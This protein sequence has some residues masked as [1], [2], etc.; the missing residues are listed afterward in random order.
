[1][2]RPPCL[3]KPALLALLSALGSLLATSP[4]FCTPLQAQA[5]SA[6]NPASPSNPNPPLKPNAN[7]T[8]EE[9]EALVR[10]QIFLD[11]AWFAP[12]KIDGLPG[13]FTTKAV[14]AYQKAHQLDP[15]GLPE[16]LPLARQSPLYAQYTLREEDRKFVGDLPSKHA[17]QSKRKFLPY[18]SLAE[19][20]CEKF[21]CSPGLLAHL[22][23]EVILEKLQPGDQLKVPDVEPFLLEEIPV[24]TQLAEV[25]E[26][27]RRRV[28]VNRKERQLTL[29]DEDASVLAS[30]PITPGS[31]TLPTPA[32]NWRIVAISLLPN[33]RWD[34]GVL[35]FGVR[36]DQFFLLP[37]GPNNPVGVAWCALSKPGIGIHGTNQ[38]DTIGRAASHGCMRL[39]NWDAIRFSKLVTA[40]V[41]VTIE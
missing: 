17:D 28:H 29:H 16:D 6:A 15:T 40:G 13:E 34:E 30:F 25:P 37:P 21:H 5:P 12:G 39:A 4:L 19:L 22:N 10:F 35:N 27:R 9:R 20:V 26:F 41:N 24:L 33:F 36:T 1:M 8:P 7:P 2:S 18:A 31:D 14:V 11:R 23:P 32:G 38:P 3:P